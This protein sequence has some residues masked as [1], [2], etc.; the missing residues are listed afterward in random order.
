MS[1]FPAGRVSKIRAMKQRTPSPMEQAAM[2]QA[3]RINDLVSL[4]G[5][6]GDALA[7]SVVEA[8]EAWVQVAETPGHPAQVAARHWVGRLVNVL[9]RAKASTHGLQLADRLP[10]G[11]NGGP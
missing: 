3:Q 6:L 1:R 9:E 11:S 10:G 2:A 5:S 8:L 4:R 7:K